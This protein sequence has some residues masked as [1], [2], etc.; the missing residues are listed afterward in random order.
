MG[1]NKNH[2]RVGFVSD[3][4]LFHAKTPTSKIVKEFKSIFTKELN[5]L[6]Y[7]FIGGDTFDKSISLSQ[8]E[9]LEGID[10]V[11]YVLRWS[12][13]TNTKL[14][15]LKGTPSHDWNMCTLY[16]HINEV[17]E[18]HADFKY[19][20]D[21]TIDI[22]EDG[23]SVLYVPDEWK[24]NTTD[25]LLE[26]KELL[27]N[28]G[29]DKVDLAIMHG[30]F[31]YQLPAIARA[32]KHDEQEYLNIV[33]HYI[34]I[35]HVHKHSS[36]DR[37]LAQGSFSRLIHGEEEP[38]GFII[39]DLYSDK[40]SRWQFIENK[41]AP[42][43]ITIDLSNKTLEESLQLIEQKVA[44][45]PHHSNI[46]LQIDRDNPLLKEVAQLYTKYFLYKWTTKVNDEAKQEIQEVHS[47]TT[48][49]IITLTKDNIIEQILSRL[50]H[51]TDE[52]KKE[53]SDI[54]QGVINE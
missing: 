50:D 39:A 52:T 2:L 8:N 51:C 40:K 17:S 53:I 38:K 22:E 26:V 25:T 33:K 34:S 16:G 3:I 32:P 10:F 5:D 1:L 13:E 4:H 36:H 54:L 41:D 42:L 35:G 19:Y 44:K 45:I 46:R 7:L 28:K 6:D 27:A 47:F 14:R 11:D 30:N 21:L 20:P 49:N 48:D 18:I 9:A 43:Y 31:H 23:L 29:L 15:V 12:K 24:P 37:I